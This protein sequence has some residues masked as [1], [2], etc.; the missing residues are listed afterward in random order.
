VLPPS[1]QQA[2]KLADAALKKYK[3][4]QLARA[5]KGYALHRSGKPQEA[6]QVG[7]AGVLP[8]LRSACLRRP[9]VRLAAV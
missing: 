5:L 7:A 8:P 3:G 2:V 9:P 4:D 6:L 1:L